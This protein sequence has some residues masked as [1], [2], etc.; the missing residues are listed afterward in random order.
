MHFCSHSED[1]ANF[2]LCSN[3]QFMF[4]LLLFFLQLFLPYHQSC[5]PCSVWS[6][7]YIWYIQLSKLLFCH[8]CMLLH[9][10]IVCF[11][12]ISWHF[13]P[14]E[15]EG[16]TSPCCLLIGEYQRHMTF[17][18]PVSMV[19]NPMESTCTGI[20]GDACLVVIT[21]HSGTVRSQSDITSMYVQY[22]G[23]LAGSKLTL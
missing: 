23:S 22:A 15:L 18:P 8:I 16:I 11:R 2:T 7:S 5:H 20:I 10:I 12:W 19:K 9:V 3:C 1:L 21:I 17:C 13:L 4:L 14:W 6:W